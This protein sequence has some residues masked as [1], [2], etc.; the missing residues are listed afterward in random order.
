MIIDKISLKN[1]RNYENV[2]IKFHN[3]VNII[4]GDNAQ[5]KTNILE[6]I[7]FLSITKSYRTSDDSVLIKNGKETS[8]INARVKAGKIP[9]KLDITINKKNKTLSVNGSLIKRVSDFIGNLNVIMMA[10]E[11]VEIIKGSPSERRNLLNI[12]LSKL[13]KE[14]ID[15]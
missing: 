9:K 5:G 6:S 7:Y 8:I 4:I 12:E 10:P 3:G 13:S 11:D 14:Y 15:I 2:K 1:Y